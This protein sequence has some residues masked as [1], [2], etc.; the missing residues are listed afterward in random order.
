LEKSIAHDI[1]D[2]VLLQVVFAVAP[3][4]TRSVYD[5]L[6]FFPLFAQSSTLSETPS[7]VV[8]G[9]DKN[10]LRVRAMGSF[11]KL[12]SLIPNETAALLGELTSLLDLTQLL[13]LYSLS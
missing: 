4:F 1:S 6:D 7:K 10:D 8:S 11:S 12:L 13:L 3:T 9:S 2:D 5:L